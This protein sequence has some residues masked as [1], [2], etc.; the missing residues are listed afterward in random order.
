MTRPSRVCR[1][2]RGVASK[3]EKPVKVPV[4]VLFALADPSSRGGQMLAMHAA[5]PCPGLFVDGSGR[6]HVVG[7][8]YFLTGERKRLLLVREGGRRNAAKREGWV[9]VLEL[10][11]RFR[12]AGRLAAG[13]CLLAEWSP[14]PMQ[15]K[16]SGR[17]QDGRAMQFEV[18]EAERGKSSVPLRRCCPRGTIPSDNTGTHTV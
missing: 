10:I 13:G 4:V 9:R 3:A 18:P 8:V 17:R 11:F 14:R 5:R 6:I 1:E 12:I 2:V 16:M 15:A 7:P